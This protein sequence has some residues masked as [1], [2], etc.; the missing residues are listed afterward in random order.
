MKT[1][2]TPSLLEKRYFNERVNL[3]EQRKSANKGQLN[4]LYVESKLRHTLAEQRVRYLV[5]GISV[6]Q[7]RDYIGFFK[8]IQ[9][10][11]NKANLPTL[12]SA[13]D[14]AY[15]DLTK[16][17]S[18]AEIGEKKGLFNRIRQLMGQEDEN[19]REAEVFKDISHFLWGVATVMSA[20]PTIFDTV[21]QQMNGALSDIIPESYIREAPEP[22]DPSIKQTASREIDIK[23]IET[24]ERFGPFIKRYFEARPG[25]G[26]AAKGERVLNGFKKMIVGA[27]KQS[28]ASFGAGKIPYI[29][30]PEKIADEI[31]RLEPEAFTELGQAAIK[32]K[33]KWESAATQAK[34]T[35]SAIDTAVETD[36]E[37]VGAKGGETEDRKAAHTVEFDDNTSIDLSATSVKDVA[38]KVTKRLTDIGEDI[39]G[40]TEPDTRTI[41]ALKMYKQAIEQL[42]K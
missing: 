10:F 24:G 30:D 25:M 40:G 42:F 22:E 21:N 34:Q 33:N 37:L 26:G 4:A 13:T 1:R 32:L 9:A 38:Q 15:E 36:Q 12:K 5:E 18:G 19:D 17:F 8:E 7:L 27:F 20:L 14:D 31:L 16:L 35:V 39:A 29:S 23:G 11:V 3:L 41:T 28:V 2:N 6:E